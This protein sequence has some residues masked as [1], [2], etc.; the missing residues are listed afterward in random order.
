MNLKEPESVRFLYSKK[1]RKSK[2]AQDGW[3]G[4]LLTSS[5]RLNIPIWDKL[6]TNLL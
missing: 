2:F 4:A 3:L 6:K 1:V 5:D